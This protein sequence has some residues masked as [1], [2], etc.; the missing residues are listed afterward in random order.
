M[1]KVMVF[2]RVIMKQL[3]GSKKPLDRDSNKLSNH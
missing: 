2:L 1:Q 3:N